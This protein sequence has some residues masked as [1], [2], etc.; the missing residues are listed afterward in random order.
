VCVHFARTHAIF[1]SGACG[2]QHVSHIHDIWPSLG[3]VSM[4][5]CMYVCK[6]AFFAAFIRQSEYTSKFAHDPV[7]LFSLVH[8][9]LNQVSHI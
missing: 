5:V 7:M 8:V 4:Y 1:Y 6:A 9:H 3:K 2:F